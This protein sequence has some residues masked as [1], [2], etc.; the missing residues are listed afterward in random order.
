[1]SPP[2]ASAPALS[3]PS[4]AA[5]P[6][7]RSASSSAWPFQASPEAGAQTSVYLATSPEVAEVSGRYF[8]KRAP[9]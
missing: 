9:A 7:A 4:W 8:E 2:T 6:P 1:V 5:R 3:A